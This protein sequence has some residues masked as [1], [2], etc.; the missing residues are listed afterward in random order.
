MEALLGFAILFALVWAGY[1]AVLMLIGGIRASAVRHSAA[2]VQRN[3]LDQTARQNRVRDG[4]LCLLNR[5]MQLAILNLDQAPDPDFRRAATAAAAA[6]E[7][8]VQFRKRQYHRLRPLLIQ[9]Y[10]RCVR[11]GADGEMLLSSLVELVEALGVQEYEAD[12]IR[13]EAERDHMQR[14]AADANSGAAFQQ[15][16]TQAQR[17][18]EQRVQVIRGLPNLADDVREQLLEA[19]DQRFQAQLFHNN[20][21]AM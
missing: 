9:H 11:R 20:A 10:R 17:E 14:P 6:R 15:H 7:V 5:A 18:H 4:R 8:P 19:E 2:V 1:R 21:R 3:R 16:L 13:Q 12:Y